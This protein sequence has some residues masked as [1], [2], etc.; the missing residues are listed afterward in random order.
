[1][2]D[3]KKQALF[4]MVVERISTVHLRA[5]LP[6]VTAPMDA[7]KLAQVVNGLADEGTPSQRLGMLELSLRQYTTLDVA[8][9]AEGL[10]PFMA[11]DRAVAFLQQ[12][13]TTT[14]A[15]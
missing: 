12:M 8:G 15:K 7:G 13:V 14:E 1:V 3:D 5:L 9:A 4:E 6:P 2:D 11:V 10:L